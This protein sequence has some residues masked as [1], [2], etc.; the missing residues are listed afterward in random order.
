MGGLLAQYC[1]SSLFFLLSVAMLCK[2]LE[3]LRPLGLGVGPLAGVLKLLPAPSPPL[4]LS[5]PHTSIL[6][7]LDLTQPSY[8]P[9]RPPPDQPTSQPSD[10]RQA[11]TDHP[12]LALASGTTTV[13]A[14]KRQVCTVAA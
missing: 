9:T 10:P 12:R 5:C 7:R 11:T 4:L 1:P 8:R 13:I 2:H 3:Q 6:A 14:S